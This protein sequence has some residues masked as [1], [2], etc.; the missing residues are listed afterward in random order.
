MS[1]RKVT[2]LG[3]G[4]AGLLVPASPAMGAA[5]YSIEP[6]FS[7]R[8]TYDD[9]VFRVNENRRD[10][11]I[12]S[13]GA[14]L[15]LAARSPRLTTSA[16]YRLG[17][18]FFA[19]G[20][21]DQGQLTH[22]GSLALA[23][24]ATRRLTLR[25][26]DSARFAETAEP[27]ASLAMPPPVPP[28]GAGPT[29]TVPPLAVA[30]GAIPTRRVRRFDNTATGG[31]EYLLGAETSV[32]GTYSF[33]LTDFDAPDLVDS[34]THRASLS[35]R[36]WVG[37]GDRV[38]ASHGFSFF[39]FDRPGRKDRHSHDATVTWSHDFSETTAVDLS[40][41]ASF[42]ERDTG[43]R[44]EPGV[45]GTAA[46]AKQSGFARYSASYA[47]SVTTS[48]GSGDVQTTDRVAFGVARELARWL[49]GEAGA[50]YSR[51]RAVGGTLGPTNTYSATASLGARVTRSLRASLGY[52]FERVEA[53]AGRTSFRR[54]QVT[55]GLALALPPLQPARF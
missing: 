32:A 11:F 44:F 21:E 18:Q 15:A 47:R 29:P 39:R 42:T 25:L 4:L 30:P 1:C 10:D 38:G 40:A 34:R 19:K 35:A 48:G 23:H 46:L 55:V 36:R 16:A 24:L 12:T 53:P 33:A 22:D 8:E 20:T 27:D 37:L 50:A 28:S 9:N 17:A 26:G 43:G 14:G 7:V 5:L 3:L 45:V 52:V 49:T 41:G 51:N 2:R 6:E 54:N 13:V 31:F